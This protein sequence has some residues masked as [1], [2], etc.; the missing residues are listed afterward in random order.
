LA[1]KQQQQRGRTQVLDKDILR[2]SIIAEAQKAK[3][4]S[5]KKR[6]RSLSYTRKPLSVAPSLS[7]LF[8]DSEEDLFDEVAAREEREARYSSLQSDLSVHIAEYKK[9]KISSTDEEKSKPI[10]VGRD[11]L[12]ELELSKDLE[13]RMSLSVSPAISPNQ[14]DVEKEGDAQ[15]VTENNAYI[16]KGQRKTLDSDS[17]RSCMAYPESPTPTVRESRQMNED[18]RREIEARIE[19]EIDA[20]FRS[21]DD[22]L[23]ERLEAKGLTYQDNTIEDLEAVEVKGGVETETNETPKE[24]LQMER[25]TGFD[26]RIGNKVQDED[27]EEQDIIDVV[28]N[29][30]LRDVKTTGLSKASIIETEEAIRLSPH[31]LEKRLSASSVPASP[32]ELDSASGP[33]FTLGASSLATDQSLTTETPIRN[34]ALEMV[35]NAFHEQAD[36]DDDTMDVDDEPNLITAVTDIADELNPAEGNTT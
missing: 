28:E 13:A 21:I 19:S 1:E 24:Q 11:I 10:G 16:D 25:S 14:L 7:P 27:E 5:S 22:N 26:P 35:N 33:T 12:D 9:R 8:E 18:K 23:K 31:K 17:K 36:N 20:F 34:N 29:L 2:K 30:D 6:S 3:Q 15:D 32:M 4:Q